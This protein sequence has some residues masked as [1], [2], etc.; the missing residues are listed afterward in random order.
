MQM[1]DISFPYEIY[2][3]EEDRKLPKLLRRLFE[4]YSH[5][6]FEKET[7]ISAEELDDLDRNDRIGKSAKL[8]AWS[9]HRPKSR[10]TLILT[11][12]AL[13]IQLPPAKQG[14]DLARFLMRVTDQLQAT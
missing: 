7:E 4:A 14:E 6:R 10:S 1:K 2:D 13:K 8:L 12:G 3:L 5:L 9:R 11:P